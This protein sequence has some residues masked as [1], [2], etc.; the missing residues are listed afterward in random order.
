MTEPT[1]EADD[2]DELIE[3]VLDTGVKKI[4]IDGVEAEVD[5]DERRRRKMERDSRNR[6]R[7]RRRTFYTVNISGVR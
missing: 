7:G 2:T 5:L 1:N 4:N 3:A 6:K